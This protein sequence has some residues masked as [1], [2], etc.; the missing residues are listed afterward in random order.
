MDDRK[1]ASASAWCGLAWVCAAWAAGAETPPPSASWP[2]WRGANGDGQWQDV[3]TKM[4]AVKLL[5]KKPMAGPCSAGISAAE[6]FVVVAD[7]DSHNDYYRAYDAETGKE[8]WTYTVPNGRNLDYN[9]SPRATPAVHQGR[10][11]CI[12]AFGD[13]HCLELKTGKCLWR[14]DYQKDFGAGKVPVWGHCTAPLIADGKLILHPG[15]VVALDPATGK[16]LWKADARGTNYSNFLAGT[17]GGVRQLIGYDASSL[18][19]WDPRTGKR[20]WELEVDNTKG[21]IV[22]QPLAVGEKLLVTSEDED[23]RLYGFDGNGKLIETPEGENEDLA[24]EI[25]TPTLQG[26]LV[27]GICEG[28]VCLDAANKLKKLWIQEKEDAFYGLSHIVAAKDRAIVFGE[29][30]TMVL[31]KADRE[32]CTILGKAKLCQTTWTHPALANGRVYIRDE[33]FFYGY[34]LG[35]KPAAQPGKATPGT[36][37]TRAKPMAFARAWG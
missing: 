13:V 23:T 9:A 10:V 24:P 27:L 15:D 18:R 4:P 34:G 6:G 5:W 30:G 7:G 35:D 28:L 32:Q 3:P 11:V 17:F 8:A 2:A 16:L 29:N 19:A 20:L 33:K 25:A 31:L 1:K 37:G 14:K 21:Y 36:E 12:G 22:P 26:E